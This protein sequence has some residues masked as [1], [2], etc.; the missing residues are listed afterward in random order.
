[1]LS[2]SLLIEK[3]PRKAGIHDETNR[4]AL[5]LNLQDQAIGKRFTA[6]RRRT[7]RDGMKDDFSCVE[8]DAE[9]I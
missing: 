6:N 7:L 5:D 3:H 1:M 4:V 8:V 2:Q 9:V